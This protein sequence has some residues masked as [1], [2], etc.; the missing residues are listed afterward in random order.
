MSKVFESNTLAFSRMKTL[1]LKKIKLLL[2][3]V[4]VLLLPLLKYISYLLKKHKYFVKTSYEDKDF[5]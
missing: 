2:L 3:L 5:V 1:F 4:V